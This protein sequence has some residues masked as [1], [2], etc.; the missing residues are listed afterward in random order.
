[1]SYRVLRFM[2]GGR[3]TAF[4]M[5]GRGLLLAGISFFFLYLSIW[6][7][8]HVLA[9]ILFSLCLSTGLLAL[10]FTVVADYLFIVQTIKNAKRH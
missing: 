8:G 4:G 10:C 6:I 9:V 7:P 1:M 2:F 3:R 5:A